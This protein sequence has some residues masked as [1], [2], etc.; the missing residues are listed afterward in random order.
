[1]WSMYYKFQIKNNCLSKN[2]SALLVTSKWGKSGSQAMRDWS[3]PKSRK[4]LR[5]FL[6]LTGYYRKFVKNYGKIA[7]PLKAITKKEIGRAHV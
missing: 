5:G 2:P 7:A 4:S 6:R 3:L 1:M